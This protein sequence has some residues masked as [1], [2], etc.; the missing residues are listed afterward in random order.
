MNSTGSQLWVSAGE[1]SGDMHAANLVRAIQKKAPHVRFAGVGG[2]DLRK[3]GFEDVFKVEDLSVMGITEVLSHLPR[4]LGM[5]KRIRQELVTR[6][7][8]AVILVD[9]PSF[10]FRIAKYAKELGIP[11]YYYI[12]PKIWAWR[13]GRVKFIRRYVDKVISILPFEV[14]FYRQHGMEIDYVGNP[15]VD[16]VD[17]DEVDAITPG[18]K[19]IGLL[20]GSRRKEITSLMPQFA[21][22]A[23]RMQ[24]A[25][26]ELEF[27]CVR[28]PGVSEENLRELWATDVPLTIHA[29]DNRYKFMRECNML[30]AASGT[31]TLESALLGTPT[32][33]AYKVSPLSFAIGKRLVKV[34]F[35]SLPNL[36]M[37]REVFPE[38]LQ[39]NADGDV[40]AARALDW[41]DNPDKLHSV[42]ADL[43]VIR[44]ML[45][46]PGAPSRAADIILQSLV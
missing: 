5:L 36:I 3:T 12:S 19:R 11:V 2:P 45:G 4:I 23:K 7:P 29:P 34:K 33:V 26:P 40:L 44:S 21:I 1:M 6:R 30:L 37:Q 41:L 35:A 42:R 31:V 39:Q 46:A 25:R 22:A 16:M 18:Q 38:L 10:N 27:H 14:D 8:D 13:T 9:A 20:P 15:L 43:A 28:A 17:W 24:A 32:L